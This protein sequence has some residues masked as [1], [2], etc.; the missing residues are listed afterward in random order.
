MKK[1]PRL[2]LFFSGLLFVIVFP[3]LSA[4]SAQAPVTT[5]FKHSALEYFVPEHRIEVKVTVKDDRGI[6][7]VRCY[8]K[9]STQAEF[10][11]VDMENIKKYQYRAILPA[12]ASYTPQIEYLFLAVNNAQQVIKTNRFTVRQAEKDVPDWQE[13]DSDAPILVKTELTEAPESIPGFSDNIEIDMVESSLRFGIVAEGIYT[14]TA[15]ASSGA[16]ASGAAAATSAGTVTAASA[17]VSTATVMA[18]GA[19]LAAAGAGAAVAANDSGGGDDSEINPN[20][21]ISWGDSDTPA[22]DA[23][24]LVFA[25]ENKGTSPTGTDGMIQVKGLPAGTHTLRITC[26]T[27]AENEGSFAIML[28]GGASFADGATQKSG[29]LPVNQSRNFQ[30]K[31]P[32]LGTLEL[33]W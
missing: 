30:V 10:V 13:V 4:I 14:A 32:D 31:V 5:E 24:E 2:S 8:F 7:L 26:V 23:F 22:G 28:S 33:Q 15:T 11:F 25:D 17:G 6:D 21:S 18:T 1:L 27:A 12:P 3:P 16:G 29:T 20:A 9:S 19:A